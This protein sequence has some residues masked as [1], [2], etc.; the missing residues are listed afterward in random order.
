[1]ISSQLRY[2]QAAM[3]SPGG[4]C[5]R[6]GRET[7]FRKFVNQD[8]SNT[9]KRRHFLGAA[10]AT[11]VFSIVPRSVLGGPGF[12]APSEKVQV[13]LVGCGGRGRKVLRGMLAEDDVRAVAVADPA[14]KFSL[15][16]FYYRDVGGRVPTAEL[17]DEH[18]AALN[19]RSK[20]AQYI[21]FEEMLAEKSD[22]DAVICATP[23]HLH[24]YVSAKCLA[25]GKH[26]YCEKPLTH[27]ISEARKIAK[28]A[29]ASG[30][31][32]QMGNQ[33]HSTD[34]L[35]QTCEWVWD[36]V[37]GDVKHVH[38]WVSGHRWNPSLTG[39]PAENEAVPDGLDWDKW[40]G[41]RTGDIAYSAKYF[42]VAWRDFWA[43]GNS[44]IGD[45]G[46]H[47][48]DAAC[49]ALGLD[50]PSSIEFHPTQP[51]NAD[52]GPHG[53]V[54][55]Y[56]FPAT[57]ERCA[58][59]VTWSDGGILPRRPDAWPSNEPL[60]GR[61]IL[62]EGTDGTL[63]CGGAG[64]APRLLG[65]ASQPTV[66]ASIP[67]VASHA[68]DW[69]D[70]IHASANSADSHQPGSHFGYGARLTEIALLG[71]LSLRT[72]KRID[73]DAQNMTARDLPAADAI[74]EEPCRSAWQF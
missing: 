13:A 9:V 71:A 12:V 27:N 26:V 49:L 39:L 14:E 32:T 42:P 69:L 73:W 58:V 50:S 21:D 43:F 2:R 30:L 44:N 23:D 56:E 40:L 38:A 66:E 4:L 45:F 60:P 61:G 34:G 10:A 11:G 3:H 29:K 41:P 57:Q 59:K 62:L 55:Y 46:C 68:R 6:N 28:L 52:I 24:A 72:G 67:R 17:I 20:C 7:Q 22:L 35:R 47:D 16:D 74:I 37:I 65:A 54:G 51:C 18:Y 5:R 1:M 64:G 19:S 48:L 36:G 33:G 53:C 8:W 70:A 31:A 15:Q 25:A 63:F